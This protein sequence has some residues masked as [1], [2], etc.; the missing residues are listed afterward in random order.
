MTGE[1]LKELFGGGFLES[2]LGLWSIKVLAKGAT[3][4][5]LL[6]VFALTFG[7]FGRQS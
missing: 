6:S 2:R 1:M 5:H 3:P 4:P 7:R